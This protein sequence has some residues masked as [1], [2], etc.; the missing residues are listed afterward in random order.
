M[1]H[2]SQNLPKYHQLFKIIENLYT[3]LYLFGLFGY[4]VPHFQIGQISTS[5]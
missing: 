4:L 1:T 2:W 3:F 5:S